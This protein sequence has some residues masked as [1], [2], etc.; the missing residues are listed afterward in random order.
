MSTATERYCHPWNAG[1]CSETSAVARKLAKSFDAMSL[2][3]SNI[4][5][6]EVAEDFRN[7]RMAITEKLEAEGW[8]VS[9]MT[10]GLQPSDK[11]RVYPPGSPAGKKIRKWRE[12]VGQ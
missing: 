10:G 6:G 4:V 2:I 12:E 5:R 9:C 1:L 3:D 7:A 8:T 11:I